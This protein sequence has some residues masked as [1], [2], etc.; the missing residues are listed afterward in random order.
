MFGLCG[1]NHPSIL[2]LFGIMP[3][4]NQVKGLY[5]EFISYVKT[6]LKRNR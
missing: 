2:Y 4:I 5:H 3:L 1:E 6:F